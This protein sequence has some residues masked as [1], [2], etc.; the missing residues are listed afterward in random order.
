MVH[1]LEHFVVKATPAFHFRTAALEAGWLA[2]WGFGWSWLV[3]GDVDSSCSHMLDAQ[4]GRRIHTVSTRVR[5]CN[6]FRGCAHA[7]DPYN[8]ENPEKNTSDLGGVAPG[9]HLNR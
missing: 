5:I 9:I 7:A 8:T 6:I 3:G 2:C 4:G 1:S